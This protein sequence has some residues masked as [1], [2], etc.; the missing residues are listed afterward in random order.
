MT[1][2][3]ASLLLALLLP[4]AAE[5]IGAEGRFLPAGTM[6]EARSGHT[7]TLLY[8]GRV[9]IAGGWSET[10]APRDSV[11]IYDPGSG[12]FAR[13]GRLQSPRTVHS[14]TLL[15][16]GR[17]LLAG[18]YG[19]GAVAQASTEIFDPATGTFASGG[20]L[21]HAQVGHT[22]TL[23]QDGH[24]LIAGGQPWPTAG[25]AVDAA[26]AEIH[27]PAAGR[28]T[29]AGRHAVV[30]TLYPPATGP[31]LPRATA[32]ADGTVLLTGNAIAEVFDPVLAEFRATGAMTDPGYAAGMWGHATAR[33]VDG[34][35][36]VTGGSDD[37]SLLASAERYDPSSQ[38]FTS[39]APMR[40]ARASHTATLLRDG[41]VLIAG[42]E[43][44]IRHGNGT[45]FG[46]S[47]ATTERFDPVTQA[48]AEGASM[49]E[50]RAG[51]TATALGDG[52]VLIVGG[53]AYE[54]YPASRSVRLAS[55]ERFVVPQRC[56]KRYPERCGASK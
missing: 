41:S 29:P 5:G 26:G 19:P 45:R 6:H 25:N 51:H 46:G 13:V 49:H 14:A 47:L 12:T 21:A 33:L 42:G 34:T 48:F 1:A 37:W 10:S 2:R 20:N 50:A 40:V 31:I 18:G 39:V 11:E 16:D 22:A 9:L 15:A 43:T 23:L 27:D 32:L 36:L 44:Q 30:N 53:T 54:P 4:A 8:D 52:S 38:R 28:S 24:V 56:A 7:A 17:V 3:V 55:A 35:V